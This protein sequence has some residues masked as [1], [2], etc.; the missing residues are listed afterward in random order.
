[1]NNLELLN[2]LYKPYRITKQGQ[3]SILESM[4]GKFVVKP[5]CKQDIKK[6]FDYLS[7]RNFDGF[8]KLVDTSRSDFDIYEY[9][10][11]AVYPKDQKAA[12]MIRTLADLHTKTTYERE[13]REDKYKEI[14][15]ILKGNLAYYKEKYTN[16][17]DHIE[18][19]VFMSPSHY[20]FIRNSSKLMNEIAFCED[21]VDEWYDLVKDKRSTRV[22][23]VH[24]N[25]SLDHYMKSSRGAFVSWDKASIDSPILDFYNF[26]EKEALEIEFST[27]LKD[28]MRTIEIKDDEKALLLLLLCMPRDIDFEENEFASCEA[29]S[30]AYDYIYRTEWLVRPY[31]AE[32]D[33]E[34]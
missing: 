10:D 5:K 34:K 11:D 7:L 3:V 1:M 25:L 21:K 17:I 33:E 24:N 32:D 18:E 13:V 22:S 16:M 2:K 26:Y 9:V 6:L 29:I 31:Y 27:L 8:P 23:V 30:S 12:D 15:D 4:E 19:E 28:Y 14:Y 20:L